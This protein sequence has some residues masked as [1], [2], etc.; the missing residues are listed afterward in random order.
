M[1]DANLK[2]IRLLG[3]SI[4]KSS[5]IFSAYETSQ[6]AVIMCVSEAHELLENKIYHR[7]MGLKLA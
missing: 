6:I 3:C 7:K 4:E 1:N 2:D 5:I